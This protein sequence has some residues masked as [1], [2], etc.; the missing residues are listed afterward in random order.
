MSGEYP[1]CEK[2]TAVAP[3]SQAIGEFLVEFLPDKGIAL[4]E[5]D[6]DSG[7]WH[8]AHRSVN[9]LLAEFFGIDMDRVE[10]ER[11]QILRD[12]ARR[13]EQNLLDQMRSPDA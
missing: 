3:Q 2:L 6:E 10:Q 1:E 13:Q 5:L 4:C 8:P 9:D 11:R 7:R 12:M